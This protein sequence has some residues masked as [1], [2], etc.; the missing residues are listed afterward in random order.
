MVKWTWC[1]FIILIEIYFSSD[2]QDLYQAQAGLG[3][4]L[5]LGLAFSATASF[6]NELETGAFE[7]L[8]VTPLREWQIIAGRVRGLWRQFLPALLVYGAATI[9]LASGWSEAQISRNAWRAFG[10]TFLFFCTVPLVGLFF[11]VQRWNFFLAWLAAC[12]LGL[13]PAKLGLALGISLPSMLLQGSMAMVTAF[14]LH[15]RLRKRLFLQRG[16]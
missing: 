11:S 1:L 15:Q 9:Y 14:L 12:L 5:L 16:D 13:L 3:L 4:L 2:S 8:L 7:L 6:R 10:G